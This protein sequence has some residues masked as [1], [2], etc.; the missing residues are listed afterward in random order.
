MKYRA[1]QFSEEERN[2][3]IEL[4]KIV[5]YVFKINEDELRSHVRKQKFTDARKALSSIASSNIDVANFKNLKYCGYSKLSLTAWYLDF[6]HSTVSYAIDKASDLYLTD[7]GFRMLYDSIIDLINKPTEEVLNRIELAKTEMDNLTWNEV[8]DTPSYAHKV[9]YST[10]PEEVLLDISN[11]YTRGY[12][13]A[14]IANKYKVVPTFIQ[15]VAKV[16]NIDRKKRNESF[17]TANQLISRRSA[18]VIPEIKS[19]QTVSY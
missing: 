7:K 12:S 17:M 6:D 10:A 14:L 2:N 15:Y 3:I 1:D 9:R 11:L 13:E 5:A 16:R 18:T 4:G 19:V 8:K